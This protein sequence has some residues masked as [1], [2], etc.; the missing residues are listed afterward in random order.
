[1]RT[2]RGAT[3]VVER[4]QRIV[5]D[6]PAAAAQAAL[7]NARGAVDHLHQ[8]IPHRAGDIEDEGQGGVSC[9]GGQSLRGL[10]RRDHRRHYCRDRHE[11][12]HELR[13]RRHAEPEAAALMGRAGRSER[14][15]C[16][17]AL[18]GSPDRG[19]AGFPWWEPEAVPNAHPASRTPPPR[20]AA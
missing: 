4:H 20:P 18:A 6:D 9:G 14:W 5:G 15:Q 17:L 2:A 11:Q 1:M 8:I 13:P 16:R 10:V 7:Q 12:R 3:W 19:A